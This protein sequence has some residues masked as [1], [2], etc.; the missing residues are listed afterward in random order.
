M[1]SGVRGPSVD[2]IQLAEI[3]LF[4][5]DGAKISVTF[6]GNPDGSNEGCYGSNGVA[7]ACGGNSNQ[8]ADKLVDGAIGDGTGNTPLACTRRE[9]QNGN[10]AFADV[11]AQDRSAIPVDVSDASKAGKATDDPDA[12]LLA[13][14]KEA[15]RREEMRAVDP[16]KLLKKQII[17]PIS[18]RRRYWPAIAQAHRDL[19]ARPLKMR[20]PGWLFKN[21]ASAHLLHSV[22]IALRRGSLPGLGSGFL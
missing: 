21:P 6:A 2:G 8:M 3:E 14:L 19:P 10:A 7:P 5:A 1:F 18:Y 9:L 4:D 22:S 13:E 17:K 16:L 15:H 11:V 20:P 12:Q